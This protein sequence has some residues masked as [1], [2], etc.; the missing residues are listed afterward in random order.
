MSQVLSVTD[1]RTKNIQF[2]TKL[3]EVPSVQQASIAREDPRPKPQ[4]HVQLAPLDSKLVPKHFLTARL[5][6]TVA[7]LI[8]LDQLSASFAAVAQTTTSITLLASVMG[9]L[10]HGRLPLM[11]VSARPDSLSPRSPQLLKT[12]LMILTVSQSC[13]Q[14]VLPHLL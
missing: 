10:E 14:L 7:L 9:L 4:F 2:S 6:E 12:Q 13:S 8:L 3:R 5:A 11:L 1:G